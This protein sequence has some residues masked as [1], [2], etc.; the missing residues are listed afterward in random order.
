MGACRS[1]V[2]LGGVA[3]PCL[4]AMAGYDAMSKKHNVYVGPMR[5]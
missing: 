2:L 1:Q 3:V 5:L 4:G